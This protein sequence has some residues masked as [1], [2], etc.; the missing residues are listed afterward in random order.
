M[1]R[2]DR[3]KKSNAENKTIVIENTLVYNECMAPVNE[4]CDKNN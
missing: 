2:S 1:Y 3:L 4:I